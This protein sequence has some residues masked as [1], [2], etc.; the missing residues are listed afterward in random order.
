MKY[1]SDTRDKIIDATM[2]LINEIGIENL[3]V[4]QIT[5]KAQVNVSAIKYHFGSKEN[6]V[7]EVL[8]KIVGNFRTTFDVF[9]NM[10][11]GP[12]EKLQ[13]FFFLYSNMAL[14][15][16]DILSNLINTSLENYPNQFAYFLKNE[17]FKKVKECVK[18]INSSY[19]ERILFIKFFQA[20]SG[21]A[22]PTLILDKVVSISE[23]NY[24]DEKVRKEYINIL[25]EGL[26]N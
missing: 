4:R 24:I 26:L 12:K 14:K 20:I 5:E 17:G 6:V 19:D 1:K 15:C 7:N 2:E 10:D 22:F 16:P 11:L 18:Q 3:T 8:L 9:E 23:I 13:E 21:I 25:V